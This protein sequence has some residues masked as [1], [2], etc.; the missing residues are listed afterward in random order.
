[1]AQA[2]HPIERIGDNIVEKADLGQKLLA[3]GT[4]EVTSVAPEGHIDRGQVYPT[5]S[6]FMFPV[7]NTGEVWENGRLKVCEKRRARAVNAHPHS[8]LR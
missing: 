4:K 7:G 8:G 5:G 3:G 2:S 1:M 6:L